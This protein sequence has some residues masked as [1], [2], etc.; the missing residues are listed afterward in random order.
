MFCIEYFHL[1]K[2]FDKKN[3]FQEILNK[4]N[5]NIDIIEDDIKDELIGIKKGIEIILSVFNDLCLEFKES[6]IVKNVIEIIPTMYHINEK[7]KLNCKEL[8]FL[9][10]IKYAFQLANLVNKDDK[11]IFSKFLRGLSK[12]RYLYK[13]AKDNINDMN[14]YNDL[15]IMFKYHLNKNENEK[16]RCIIKILIQEYKN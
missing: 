5:E 7:Y 16:C 14:T 12:Y 8:Y 2:Y 15:I 1:G 4:K 6:S 9:F 3:I 11:N 10:Q 13:E